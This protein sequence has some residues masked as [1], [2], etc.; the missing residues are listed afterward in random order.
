MIMRRTWW[1]ERIAHPKGETGGSMRR[2]ILVALGTGAVITSAATIGIGAALH[3]ATQAMDRGECAAAMHAVA[4]QRERAIT[5]CD[6]LDEAEAAVC[7]AQARGD[8]RVRSAELEAEYRR[9]EQSARALVRARIDARYE[10]DR[11]RCEPLRGFRKDKCLINAHALK[12][13]SLLEASAPYELRA[14]IF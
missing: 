12:G 1:R 8:E 9:T 11:A 3:P 6:V 10:V 13:R 4:L 7:Q 14:T 2:A 5:R